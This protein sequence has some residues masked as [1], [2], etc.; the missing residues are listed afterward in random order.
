MANLMLT[1]RVMRTRTRS[2]SDGGGSGQSSPLAIS[3]NAF[4]DLTS[5][6]GY[7]TQ[8]TAGLTPVTALDQVVGRILDRSGNNRHA[9]AAS[10]AARGTV[11][12]R[13]N[14]LLKSEQ[15]DDAAWTKTDT[16][17]T[18]N[19]I[20]APDGTL[21]ADLLTEGVAGTSQVAQN[22]AETIAANA[23]VARIRIKRGNHDWVRLQ[24][25]DSATNTN[26]GQCWV[27]LATGALGT[28]GNNGTG[29]GT[30]AS[31][32]SAAEGFWTI[33][34]S[35]VIPTA[36]ARL[37]T[38][39]A[40][41]DNSMTRVSNGT[42]YQWGAQLNIGAAA[43]RYQRV[44]TA[45]DYDSVG[46][47][48]YIR[49]NG[50]NTGYTASGLTGITFPFTLIACAN[51]ASDVLGGVL[52]LWGGAPPYYEIQK[53]S[54]ANQWRAF[55]RGVVNY[56]NAETGANG[57]PHVLTQE[58]TAT[59]V[60]LRIDGT[61][62]TAPTTQDNAVGTLTQL[63]IFNGGGGFF[64]GMFLGGAW[65]SNCSDAQRNIV[66]TYFARKGDGLNA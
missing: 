23:A 40:S 58:M 38:M 14:W 56:S 26:G 16:T 2:A 12:A 28:V 41:A 42:R 20:T 19:S 62:P 44:N 6:L 29:T 54:T 37:T 3:P 10:D 13:W 22:V 60:N 31:V 36:G 51:A 17:V 33:Q 46:F 64:N 43:F 1:R 4:Y 48:V 9:I 7:L 47:P 25:R 61:D 49:G 53:S 15:F 59:T 34:I 35:S 11:S 50:T 39:S 52:S 55:D 45:T 24:L 57:V 21:T 30:V 65:K 32:L 63:R 27:N 18:A 66:E 5:D 8:D